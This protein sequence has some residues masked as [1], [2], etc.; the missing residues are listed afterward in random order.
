MPYDPHRTL[1]HVR[2]HVLT[3]GVSE[4]PPFIVRNGDEAIGPEADVIRA[5][6]ASVGARVEWQWGSQERHLEALEKYHLDL[7]AGG[8]SPKTPWKTK[9]AVTRPFMHGH[10]IAVPP[11][12][13]GFLLALER[14]LASVER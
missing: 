8:L 12:E 5:F 10:A 3:A 14:H 9:V 11:G 13:N 2:G 6:A 1:D 4:D 7:V